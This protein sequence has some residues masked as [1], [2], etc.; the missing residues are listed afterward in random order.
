[1]RLKFNPEIMGLLE[2]VRG[3]MDAACEPYLVGGAVRDAIIGCEVNDLDFAMEGD[4]TQL[5]K[6]VAKR[7]QVPF[8]LLDD[9][10]H[11]ARVLYRDQAGQFSP[12]DFVQF[13][14]NGLND[15]LY[16]RDFTINAIA[17]SVRDLSQIIDPLNGQSDLEAGL[18]RPCTALALLDD[19]VRVLRGI[20]VA[21]QFDLVYSPDLPS[22]MRAA[23]RQLPETSNERQRDE[24]FKILEGPEPAQ[25]N[26]VVTDDRNIPRNHPSTVFDCFHRS[27][28]H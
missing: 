20:R 10:R 23:S 27:S 26:I 6:R 25:R 17:L 21:L 14:G 2:I 28:G 1:M 3:E 19:P 16:N 13:T 12:L 4:P 15:D 22:L 9:E 8:F 7:L 5:A 18:L 24:F 11:T